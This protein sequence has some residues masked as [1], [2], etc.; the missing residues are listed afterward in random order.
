MGGAEERG[1][2][3]VRRAAPMA[4]CKDTSGHFPHCQATHVAGGAGGTQS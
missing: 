2:L 1:W 3:R 4:P